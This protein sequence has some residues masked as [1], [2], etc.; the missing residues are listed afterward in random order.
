MKFDDNIK[1]A[2]IIFGIFS[3]G[4]YYFKP[5]FAFH[6]D[7]SFKQ[8]GLN[9]DQTIYPFW[10]VVLIIGIVSYLCIVVKKDEYI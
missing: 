5:Q 7:G 3:F 1:M 6:P 4:L 9:K 8:F 10:L 2:I